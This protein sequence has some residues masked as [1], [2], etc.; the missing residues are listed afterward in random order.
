MRRNIDPRFRF[1]NGSYIFDSNFQQIDPS[2]PKG[3]ILEKI[4]SRQVN[5]KMESLAQK[6][7]AEVA[8]NIDINK[9]GVIGEPESSSVLR[10]RVD[11]AIK[12]KRKGKTKISEVSSSSDVAVSDSNNTVLT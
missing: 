2:Q 1:S 12:A 7:R 10:K 11:K 5:D 9:D 8:H 4:L 3:I 6:H